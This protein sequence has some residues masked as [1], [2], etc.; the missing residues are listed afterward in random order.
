MGFFLFYMKGNLWA[1]ASKA[2]SKFRVV[3]TDLITTKIVHELVNAGLALDCFFFLNCLLL[4]STNLSPVS[5]FEYMLVAVHF[6]LEMFPVNWLHTGL[7]Y[8]MFGFVNEEENAKDFCITI[9]LSF[10]KP[11][12]MFLLVSLNRETKKS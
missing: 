5:S 2:L 8:N 9:F 4:W 11:L 1:H 10:H 3:S 12:P 6:I 7:H